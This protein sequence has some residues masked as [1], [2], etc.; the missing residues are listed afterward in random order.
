MPS[1][2]DDLG[3]DE[4]TPYS[5]RR[6]KSC[7]SRLS[8]T[9]A[10]TSTPAN[11]VS[12]RRC[13][14]LARAEGGRADEHDLVLEGARRCLA[15]QHVGGRDVRECAFARLDSAASR[16]LLPSSGTLRPSSISEAALTLIAR[17]LM[18]L[19]LRGSDDGRERQPRVDAAVERRQ[20]GTRLRRPSG[21]GAAFRNPDAP[22]ACVSSGRLQIAPVASE[23]RVVRRS[24][25]A[26][27]DG[28]AERMLHARGLDWLDGRRT[29]T[30]S[31]A[32]RH[33]RPER[34]SAGLRRSRRRCPR[35]GPTPRT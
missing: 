34:L 18:S 29:S 17:R 19:C 21:S 9:V 25:A 16:L 14:D 33:A 28:E 3:L 24:V 5:G 23:E 12:M 11:S 27:D 13:H 26:P 8:A 30:H 31:R 4:V 2:S 15:A 35:I 22:A 1:P 32:R 10:C 20:Q 6:M 7:C